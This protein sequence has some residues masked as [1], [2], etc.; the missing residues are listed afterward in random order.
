M[1][2]IVV[3][4][5]QARIVSSIMDTHSGLFSDSKTI[6]AKLQ[7]IRLSSPDM[8]MFYYYKAMGWL[9][10]RLC[11]VLHAR[12]QRGNRGPEPPSSPGKPQSFRVPS[13]T[14]PDPMENHKATRPAFNGGPSSACQFKW[15]FA[16]G[17][18]M[19]RF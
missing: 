14:G 12:I 7:I 2:A 3:H 13:K 15:R 8:N 9:D 16:G 11:L 10:L 19:A 6:R 4:L 1:V 17:L 18:K 5:S